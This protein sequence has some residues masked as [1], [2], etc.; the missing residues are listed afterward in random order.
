MKFCIM[1]ELEKGREETHDNAKSRNKFSGIFVGKGERD[2]SAC[3]G[4]S[5]KP[6]LGQKSETVKEDSLIHKTFVPKR[7]S[8]VLSML[9]Y[10]IF[11]DLKY[12]NAAHYKKNAVKISHI[13]IA[14][15][16]VPSLT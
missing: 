13:F 15:N 3:Q 6:Y 7:P 5:S 14:E 12:W 11:L 10:V 1:Q 16:T 2:F 9:L 8:F 4:T